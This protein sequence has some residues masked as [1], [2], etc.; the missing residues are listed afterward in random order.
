MQETKFPRPNINVGVVGCGNISPV[1]LENI[2]RNFSDV[3]NLVAC[4]DLS[5]ERALATSKK[6]DI[7]KAVSYTHLTLPTNR[8]V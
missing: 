6:F 2:C 1:Y 8:E 4:S 7:P 5:N 3:I